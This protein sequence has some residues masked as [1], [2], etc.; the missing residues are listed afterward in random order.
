MQASV[1]VLLQAEREVTSAASAYVETLVE[2]WKAR[3]ALETLAS[4]RQRG[5]ALGSAGVRTA[6]EMPAGGASTDH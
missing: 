6:G 5:L 3:A 2:H 4:G 1:F